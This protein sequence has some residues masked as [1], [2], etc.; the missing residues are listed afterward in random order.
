MTTVRG[1]GPL[2]LT[3]AVVLLTGAAQGLGRELL[4]ELQR[5]GARVVALDVD[6]AALE[7]LQRELAP[8][9]AAFP[10]DV[11]DA[12]ASRDVVAR[13]LAEYGRLDVLVVNAGIERVSLLWDMEAESFERV[14]AVNLLGAFNIIKPSLGPVASA[15]GHILAIASVAALLPW[16]LGAAYG[17]SKAGLESLMRS[18]RFELAG[19]GAS[20]GTAYLGFVDTAMARRAFAAPQAKAL[21]DRMPNRLLGV[22]PVQQAPTVARAL[23]DAIERRQTRCF[24]P[25]MTRMT[26]ILRGIYPLFDRWLVR[27]SA[28]GESLRRRMDGGQGGGPN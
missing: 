15:G 11:G 16:P 24:M 3:G 21:L 14:I 8:G 17:A 25:F 23:A 13:V 26:F 6:A 28:L 18:L 22:L 2:S 7:A 5:R 10:C 19:S 20:C 27:R 12:A 4:L 1:K 9:G